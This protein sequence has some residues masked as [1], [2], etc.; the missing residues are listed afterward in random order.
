MLIETKN[1]TKTYGDKTV[2]KRL[3]LTVPKGSLVA[4]LGTNGAGKSTTIKMLTGLLKPSSG[5]V[6]LAPGIKMGMVFQ[7]SVLDDELTVK[8][9]LYNRA[10][11]YKQMDKRWLTDLLDLTGLNGFLGQKYG[12]LSGGQRRRA[13]IARALLNKPD[14][15]FLDEPTTGLD[16]QT[17]QMIWNL[18]YRLKKEQGL[19]IFLTTHY[20]EEAENAELTYIIEQGQVLAQGTAMDL[21]KKYAKNKLYLVPRANQLLENFSYPLIETELGFLAE[22]LTAQEAIAVLSRYREALTTFEFKP[23]TVNDAF[24]AITGK[25]ID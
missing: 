19:T 20:L 14:L 3:N 13:D 16:I 8:A 21:K 23:G 9:N 12:T 15:L 6:R 25:E 7:D 5:E 11:L 4:Y 24:I 2:V 1:L 18:L 22:G 17:R 10:G